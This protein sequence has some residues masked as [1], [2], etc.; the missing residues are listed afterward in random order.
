MERKCK[1]QPAFLTVFNV[2]VVPG[3]PEPPIRNSSGLQLLSVTMKK[4]LPSPLY[5]IHCWASSI[6]SWLKASASN[7]RFWY[8]LL[9]DN[10]LPRQN[11]HFWP[12]K[13]NVQEVHSLNH[14]PEDMF[15]EIVGDIL[16]SFNSE[17]TLRAF[18][19]LVLH[20]QGALESWAGL[21]KRQNAGQST[22]RVLILGWEPENLHI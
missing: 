2:L 15:T 3:K 21:V 11:V 8:Q 13:Q 16:C 9:V 10:C 22:P 12:N 1:G 6:F 7:V 20:L 18:R 4:V 5:F 17:W 14:W 19:R